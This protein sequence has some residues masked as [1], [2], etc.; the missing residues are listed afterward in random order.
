[1]MRLYP[2][3]D[4]I[5]C[6]DKQKAFTN[7]HSE[8]TVISPGSFSFNDFAFKVYVPATKQIEDCVIPNE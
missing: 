4:L 1:M 7:T 2:L 3:P 8:C 6:A 5:V